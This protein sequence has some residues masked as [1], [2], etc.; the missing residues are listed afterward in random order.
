MIKRIFTK[1]VIILIVVILYFSTS[2]VFGISNEQDLTDVIKTAISITITALLMLLLYFINSKWFHNE[3]FIYKNHRKEKPIKLKFN[4]IRPFFLRPKVSLYVVGNFFLFFGMIYIYFKSF[5]YYNPEYTF[6]V[7]IFG[8]DTIASR[9]T[10]YVSFT[11]IAIW[12][13]IKEYSFNKKS[14]HNEMFIVNVAKS[15]AYTY[16]VFLVICSEFYKL[17]G[18]KNVSVLQKM[19]D[20]LAVDASIYGIVILIGFDRILKSLPS[21]EETKTTTVPPPQYNHD[22]QRNT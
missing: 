14:E 6:S 19:H 3:K 4:R 13:F 8:I 18:L 17:F 11:V 21:I 1:K 12:L 20:F 5:T 10:F 22:S 15:S 2:L 16:H 9:Y 7:Y